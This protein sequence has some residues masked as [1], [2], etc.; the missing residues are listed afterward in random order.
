M[1][2]DDI[3]SEKKLEKLKT[4]IMRDKALYADFFSVRKKCREKYSTLTQYLEGDTNTKR[5]PSNTEMLAYYKEL[6]FRGEQTPN[7]E[8]EHIL[9]KL[10]VRS[11]S[12]VAVISLLTKPYPC[13]G[14]CIYCPNEK[15]M[16]KSYL[17]KEPAAA[18]ALANNFSPYTQVQ[19]R[20]KALVSNGHP[21]DKLEVIVIGG[22]WSFYDEA[23]QEEFIYEIFRAVNEFEKN[24]DP[25]NNSK[26]KTLEELQKENETARARVIGLSIETRPDFITEKE[27]G[28]LR[29]LG[30][31][32]IEIGVQHLLNSVLALNKRD[33]TAKQISDA[34]EMMR[35]A[36]FKVVYHMMPNLFGSTPEMDIKMFGDLFKGKDFQP[37]MLK[38]YPCIVL[39]NSYL[40]TVWKKGDFI[41]YTDDELLYVL[42]EAKKQ[43]P[44]YVRILRVIRDIPSEYIVAGSTISNLRQ[45]IL[46]DQKKQNWQCKCIRC[47]EVRN[48]EVNLDEYVLQKIVYETKTGTEVFLSF[49]HKTENKCAAFCRLRLPDV[50]ATSMFSGTLQVLHECALIRELHTYGQLMKIQKKGDQSQHRGF[51]IRLMHEAERIAQEAGYSKMAVI[52]GVGVR[53]YY[54]NKLGY[55]LEGTYMVKKLN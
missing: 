38:M 21:V 6:V 7:K 42:R 35:N 8:V 14:K 36:G 24:V 43:V 11:N 50:N 12:G 37:D 20:M 30:V 22:T 16:P 25:K 46:E 19:N 4:F 29:W 32:K 31:T 2:F 1:L 10:K 47:R 28:R 15:E 45:V 13:P 18:R 3:H 26:K 27:L 49:E 44:K 41:P 39:R 33:M 17:S 53:E 34:T 40:Y 48:E 54:R 55:T 5:M 52:S 23:Y 51:G 9:R